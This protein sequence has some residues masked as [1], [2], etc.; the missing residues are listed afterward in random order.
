MEKLYDVMKGGSDLDDLNFLT[1]TVGD[2]ARCYLCSMLPLGT[3]I[4]LTNG[5]MEDLR[6]SVAGILRDKFPGRSPTI[7]DQFTLIPALLPV[8]TW[9]IGLQHF[10]RST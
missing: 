3:S 6:C 1:K 9:L 7:N 5:Q 10:Q 8:V 2:L 4:W